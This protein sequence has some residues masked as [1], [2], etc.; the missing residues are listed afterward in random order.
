MSGG[1]WGESIYGSG[2]YIHTSMVL[3]RDCKR[4]SERGLEK[5]GEN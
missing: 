3:R 5:R 4:A 1:D 2:A